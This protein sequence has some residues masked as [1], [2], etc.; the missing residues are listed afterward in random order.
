MRRVTRPISRLANRHP[1]SQTNKSSKGFK[2]KHRAKDLIVNGEERKKKVIQMKRL[3]KPISRL[4]NRHSLSQTNKSSKGFKKKHLTKN[5]IVN[6]EEQK[7]KSTKPTQEESDDEV[8]E[9]EPPNIPK[10]QQE[11]LSEM[12]K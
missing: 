11:M 1:P 10:D 6:G 4:A 2:K 8:I 9:I 3:T 5:L 12:K 7:K